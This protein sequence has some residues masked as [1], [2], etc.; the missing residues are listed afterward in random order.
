VPRLCDA[1]PVFI[2]IF[3]R[4]FG[5]R[6]F[7]Q[8]VI[9]QV[10]R[11]LHVTKT[12]HSEQKAVVLESSCNGTLQNG[13]MQVTTNLEPMKI[14]VPLGHCPSIVDQKDENTPD[15]WVKRHPDMER[16]TSNHPFNS[17][18]PLHLL[19][20]VGW[21]T[22]ASLCVVRNHGAVPKLTWESHRLKVS[23]VPRPGEFCMDDL[24]SGSIGEIVSI[25]VTFICSGNR[26]KEQNMVK[27]TI[28][29]NWGPG[30]I[31]NSVWTGIRLCDLLSYVGVSK[32]SKAHQYVHFEGPDGELPKGET[33]SYGTSIAIGWALDKKRDILLAYKQNGEW[34]LP[35]HG[36]PL[37]DVV[38]GATGCRMVKWLTRIIVSDKPSQ[39]HYHFYDNRVLPPHVDTE[40][41]TKEGW[42]FDPDNMIT[43]M[44]VNSVMFEPRHN[45]FL[46]LQPHTSLKVSGYAYSGGGHCVTRVDISLDQGKSWEMADLVRPEDD[47]AAAR[48]TDKHWCWAWWSTHIPSERLEQCEEIMCR[49]QD[50]AHNTQPLH[51]TW[52]LMGM[53][54]NCVFR[55]KVHSK[56]D[57]SGKSALWF[58]HPTMPGAKKGGWM[59]PEAGKYD[60]AL[61]SEA[62]Y[63]TD[64]LPNRE[65]VAIWDPLNK[66]IAGPRKSSKE[67]QGRWVSAEE[68]ALHNSRD[69][70]WIV[71]HGNVYDCTGYL[72]EHPGGPSS[73]MLMAG[74]EDCTEEFQAVH[75]H[76]AWDLL[77]EHYFGSLHAS[78][79]S[80]APQK[81]KC[82]Q[83][84]E[85]I[86]VSHDTRIFRFYRPSWLAIPTGMHIMLSA[87]IDGK[88]VM[89][90]YTPLSDEHDEEH[91]DLLIKV[92]FAGVHPRF[93]RGGL[94]SQHLESIAIDQTIDVKGPMG[95]VEYKGKSAFT[96]DGEARSC[97]FMSFV[98]GGTGITPAWQIISAVLR[99]PEDHT[100]LRLVYANRSPADILLRHELDNLAANHKERFQC[101]YT[102]DVLT[103]QDKGW[104]FDVGFITKDMLEKHIF[105]HEG[106]DA[107]VG[108]CGPPIMIEKCCIP[109]LKSLGYTGDAIFQF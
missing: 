64:L 95:D 99:D 40:V 100:Q 80:A 93:P 82:L 36:F 15:E 54:N 44:N 11:C 42:W 58:E 81:G 87:T 46:V 68:V 12:L 10:F 70:A 84:K 19:Q 2:G 56:E 8:F 72:K 92:Y 35:D 67:R 61:A 17:E 26:R 76:T 7:F 52:N 59:T 98:V 75:S 14:S 25:P 16:L 28:G 30:A 33:G 62:S 45:S 69:S 101:W 22:P 74:Q 9:E 43:H 89:R 79:V 73:I 37:R 21:V 5:G 53:M 57:D 34:L 108:I 48:S 66:Q 90:P 63:S 1:M 77:E 104:A 29:F 65:A 51:L 47:I 50:S 32:P 13:E 102:V 97:K 27:K 91:I 78:T 4:V 20:E 107:V 23:G 85:K 38:P 105:R 3:S 106:S 94:M 103:D 109:H 83:L 71:V 18:A 24:V 39:N 96:L 41:A 60:A 31:G 6:G 88:K 49:A 55:I 86:H